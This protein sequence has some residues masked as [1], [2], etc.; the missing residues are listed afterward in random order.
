MVG[1]MCQASILYELTKE[2]STLCV[3]SKKNPT[4]FASFHYEVICDIEILLKAYKS[5]RTT[6]TES[7]FPNIKGY[8]NTLILLQGCVFHDMT[9]KKGSLFFKKR[10]KGKEKL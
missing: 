2:F 5:S 1:S 9:L 3:V 7:N 4:F 10:A 8:S 6:D